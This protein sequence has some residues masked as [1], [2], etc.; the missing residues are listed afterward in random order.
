MATIVC[1][2]DGGAQQ[3]AAVA[4][5][6]ALTSASHSELLVV[7][8]YPW[9]RFNESLGNAYELTVKE[10]AK[11]VLARASAQLGEV[12]HGTRAIPALSAPKALH[13]LCAETGAQ[14]LVIGSCHRGAVGR[15]VLGGVGDRVVHGSPCP[16][17]IAPRDAM[18]ITVPHAIGV[19]FDDSA[20]ARAALEVA[21]ALA[22]ATGATLELIGVVEPV[23][24]AAPMGGVTYPYELMAESQRTACKESLEAGVAQVG[25]R[26][27]VTTTQLH[28]PA[29]HCLEKAGEE[30]DLLVVGSRGYGPARSLMV[31]ST[32]RDLAH[33]APCPLV[34]VPR[35]AA[36]EADAAAAAEILAAT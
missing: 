2:V 26:V 27:A 4:L 32:G 30:L 35:A 28:G 20:E 36:A 31:G 3:H 25:K 14:L 1:A 16:V 17:A 18:E 9:S 5:A 34:L 29:S 12:A 8:V 33:K 13:A 23:T 24:I 19:G 11:E 22:Q 6:A 10:D 15:T 7:T 21:V